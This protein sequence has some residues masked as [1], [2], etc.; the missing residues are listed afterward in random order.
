MA[1]KLDLVDIL[2]LINTVM[3]T[4]GLGGL[5]VKLGEKWWK[6]LIPGYRYYA[7]S[8]KVNRARAGYVLMLLEFASTAVYIISLTFAVFDMERA[9]DISEVVALVLEVFQIIYAIR[10]FFGICLCF[11]RS[12]H[13][14][15]LWVFFRPIAAMVFGFLP[16]FKPVTEVEESAD[17]TELA[18]TNPAKISTEWVE[19]E[20][21]EGLYINII[22]R[23]V[24]SGGTRRYLLKN[25][26]LSI[27]KGEM[28]LLLGGSGS[29]KTTFV[30]AITGYEKANAKI[31]LDGED[32]Y[33]E[34]GKMKHRLGF[35]PQSELI[36]LNDTV[37]QTLLDAARLRLPVNM[38]HDAKHEKVQDV[39]D[40]LGL[41]AGKKGLVGKKS[42][43][44]KKRISIGTELIGDPELFVLD[45]PDSGLD[46]IIARELFETLH[47]IAK[48]GKIVI[49]ITHTP[50]RVADLF[51]KVI[52]L[53]RDSGRCGRLA[54]YGSPDEA[55]KFF[56][57][58]TMEKVV[59]TINKK[60]EG[61]EGR[62]DEFIARFAELR[63][64]GNTM[65]TSDQG[66]MVG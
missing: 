38:G 17:E 6:C 45:E 8:K 40:L 27:P 42:G 4:A 10:L 34:Y 39:M 9:A 13:W 49:V 63:N 30:N 41:D 5:L 33:A 19:K 56:D 3:L 51:D 14:T 44:M 11:K 16:S 60:E 23:S 18:G 37:E 32:L 31:L 1:A 52:V 62:A 57:K 50:D 2:Q 20:T 64:S 35:V 47:K 65:E 66:G 22:D 28:V 29:G 12:R 61:G 54:F 15:W 25:I 48:E 58:P 46:G 24:K 26:S 7:I 55:R 21:N 43:G 59:Q 53:A 36:R